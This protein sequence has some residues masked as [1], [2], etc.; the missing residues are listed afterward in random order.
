MENTKELKTEISQ[1]IN[2]FPIVILVLPAQLITHWAL[3]MRKLKTL[4]I[5]ISSSVCFLNFVLLW[6]SD[7]PQ[8][9]SVYAMIRFNKITL[10]PYAAVV[11]IGTTGEHLISIS[12]LTLFL[13][14]CLKKNHW[15]KSYPVSIQGWKKPLMGL[16]EKIKIFLI[17]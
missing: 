9:I 14:D 7:I 1:N 15:Q 13:S 16:A 2:N 8:F 3:K 10:Q 5:W 4:S 11:V 17:F 12:T 6:Q